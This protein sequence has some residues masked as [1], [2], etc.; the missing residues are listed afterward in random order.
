MKKIQY[1]PVIN[2]LKRGKKNAI[3]RT[4]LA[5]LT[6]LNDRANRLAIESARRNGIKIISSS[7]GVG[8]YIAE[9]D[10]EWLSSLEEYKR[11]A[12]SEFT[13]YNNGLKHLD[14]S[15]LTRTVIPVKAH[16]RHLKRGLPYE[17]QL[18]VEV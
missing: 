1:E 13:L 15:Y 16:V 11:R 8:Y 14:N 6:G 18:E 4:Q 9:N 7:G 12:I 3:S 5:T 10:E 17:G 2:C